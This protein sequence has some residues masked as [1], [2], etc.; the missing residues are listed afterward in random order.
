M[1]VRSCGSRGPLTAAA[2]CIRVH[3]NRWTDRQSDFA[4]RRPVNSS[5][6]RD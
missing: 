6:S 3:A 1:L 2:D 4:G 5:T